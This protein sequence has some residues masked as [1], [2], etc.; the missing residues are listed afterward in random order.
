MQRVWG[1]K[2]SSGHGEIQCGKAV[3]SEVFL[4]P[5]GKEAEGG[6]TASSTFVLAAL[7]VVV[8]TQR[9]WLCFFPDFFSALG[10]KRLWERGEARSPGAGWRIPGCCFYGPSGCLEHALGVTDD[11]TAFVWEKK[12]KY[13]CATQWDPWACLKGHNSLRPT[14]K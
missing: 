3:C 14:S 13:L 10:L 12:L 8:V 11:V 4:A 7:V 5:A 2:G 1:S 6:T 9:L